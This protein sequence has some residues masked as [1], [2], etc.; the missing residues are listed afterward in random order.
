MFDPNCMT[1]NQAYLTRLI[2]QK[3]SFLCVGLDPDQD[4]I[5]RHYFD[6]PEPFYCFC[7]DVVEV[8]VDFAI[9]YKINIAFFEALGPEGWIQLEK[10]VSEIPQELFIIADAKRADIGNTSKKYAE[11][12]FDRLKADALTLHP[13]MGVD[14]LL[15]FLERR[16]KWSVVLALT[17]NPGAADFEMRPLEGSGS[18]YEE[19]IRK[20]CH[21]GYSD[22]LMFVVGATKS[23]NMSRIRSLAPDSFFLVPGVG[24]QGGSLD[25]TI[26]F[27]RNRNEGL[28]IN[29]GRSIMYPKG[30]HS[31][32]EDIK[33]AAMHYQVQMAAWF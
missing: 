25:D 32:R 17:S 30:L 31:S 12:Y 9:A 1:K 27:G 10:L 13:Y 28:I 3:K 24:E 33:N 2:Q 16:D 15:P 26:R 21:S 7:R 18:L 4:K 22:N 14:S 20:F 6:R 19:V 11:Y 5:P 23:D 8:T 29:V